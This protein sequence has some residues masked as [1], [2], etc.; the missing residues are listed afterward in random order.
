[1]VTINKRETSLEGLT[2][3]FEM[4]EDTLYTLINQ[5]KQTILTPKATITKKDVDEI[6]ELRAVRDAIKRWEK[7]LQTATGKDIYTCKSTIIEL[8]KDQYLIKDYYRGTFKF[9][10]VTHSQ[11]SPIEVNEEIA[12]NDD[13]KV[14]APIGVSL[15]DP[16]VCSAI[17]CGYASYKG[18]YDRGQLDS[19]LYYIM[20]EFDALYERALKN[21]PIYRRICE[22]KQE[23]RQNEE[24]QILLREEF[25]ESYSKEYISKLWRKN[26]P[27]LIADEAEE[28]YLNWY[29]T[30][31]EKGKY[32]KCSRCGQVKLATNRYFSQNKT[33]ADGFYSIC[34]CCRNK[35]G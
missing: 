11:A 31:V 30:F 18:R 12:V 3:Q 25:G 4:G 33:S 7:K 1:M 10:S 2:A 6:P 9:K 29:Y 21:Y 14:L 8:R 34:K 13:E 17:L 16:K 35:K 28:D 27:E 19:D 26:I 22:Y 24:I 23:N 5:N 20:I 15:A 32:K